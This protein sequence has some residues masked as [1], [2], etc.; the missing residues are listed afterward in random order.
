MT[1]KEKQYIKELGQLYMKTGEFNNLSCGGGYSP[2]YKPVDV[3]EYI[4]Q[5]EYNE[6]LNTYIKYRNAQRY[7]TYHS[8]SGG[9]YYEK[10][11]SGDYVIT[12]N[13]KY[14]NIRDLEYKLKPEDIEKKINK[15]KSV[16][17]KDYQKFSRIQVNGSNT[18]AYVED[19]NGY[20]VY[21]NNVHKFIDITKTI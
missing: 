11:T 8:C 12:E 15:L 21:D 2:K 13:G 20:F 16:K 9:T 6:N 18:F 1:N 3:I 4:E 14:I 19:D 7:T 17:Y 5:Q 10:S